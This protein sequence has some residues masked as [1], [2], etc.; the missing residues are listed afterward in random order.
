VEAELERWIFREGMSG[1]VRLLGHVEDTRSLFDRA[2]ILVFPSHLNGP[3]RSVF[4]AGAHGI[5]S[6][7]T[8]VDRIEDIVEDGVTGLITRERDP[9]ALADAILRLTDGRALH[10]R[11]GENARRKYVEQFDGTRIGLRM[12]EIYRSCR[13]A[14]PR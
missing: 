2:D 4:E 10:E 1:T 7:V 5:P 8:M 13:K 14:P 11:L 3:G 9:R 6:I 12:L